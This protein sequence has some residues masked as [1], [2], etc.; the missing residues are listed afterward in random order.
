M[1]VTP[2]DASAPQL[3]VSVCLPVYNEP[4]LRQ[5]VLDMKKV[6]DSLPYSYEIVVVDDGSTNDCLSTIKDLDVRVI[7]HRR[8]MGGGIARV[9]AMRYARGRLILQSDADGTYPCTS[10]PE[11]LKRM[12]KA[13]MVIGARNKESAV[14]W[15]YVRIVMKWI[16]KTLASV[17]AGHK[18]PDLNSGM[19]VYERKLGLKYAYLYP[20][21]H[22][23][24][25]TMTLAFI[26]EGLKVDFVETD[27]LKRE[28]RSSFRPIRDTYNY[29]ITIIR[30][31]VYF[32]P[33][34]LLMPAVL[35]CSAVALFFTCR[36]LILFWRINNVTSVLWLVALVT[37]T[38][39]VLSD[40][41]ARLSRQ[42]AYLKPYFWHDDIIFEE[43]EENTLRAV[44]DA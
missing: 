7:R 31:I 26:T 42:I 33:L 8:N 44:A 39:A 21:G 40:Q 2:I 13:D 18:I 24:M 6:M 32:D 36:D 12:D 25:S 43:R 11:M 19:R 3:D 38:L 14:D 35:F 17:L 27:Y 5:T 29:A 15:R 20:R 34:R 28:G 23:I 30:T 22:S 4:A 41:F 9:T 1:V 37:L 10:I 16:L